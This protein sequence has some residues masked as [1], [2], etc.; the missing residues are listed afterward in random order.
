MIV[1]NFKL[2]SL[3]CYDFEGGISV[4]LNSSSYVVR[5]LIKMVM[6]DH[7]NVNIITLHYLVL[8]YGE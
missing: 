1:Y 3:L 4:T 7:Y 5:L 2:I 8:E 6:N